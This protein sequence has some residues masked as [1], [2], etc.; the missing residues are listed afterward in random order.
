MKSIQIADPVVHGDTEWIEVMFHGQSF[1]LHQIRKMMSA[2]VLACRTGTPPHI[3][4]ELYG[5]RMAFIP[6]MPALASC[7][8]TQYLSHT[9]GK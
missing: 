1:M 9:A 4:E 7:W 3:I 2:L 5:P 8:N 6:K